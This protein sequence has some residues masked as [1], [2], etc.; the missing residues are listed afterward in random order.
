MPRKLLIR[1]QATIDRDAEIIASGPTQI[2]EF[3]DRPDGVEL[4]NPQPPTPEEL[5]I[6][7]AWLRH[8]ADDADE[9][10][11]KMIHGE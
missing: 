1:V 3:I 11:R 6:L 9:Q 4:G 5:R 8:T 2:Y 10:A 7:S